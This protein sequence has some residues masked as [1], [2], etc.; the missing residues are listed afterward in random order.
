M[1]A[2]VALFAS[3][4]G[5]SLSL[6]AWGSDLA[7]DAK[8]F[9]A[10]E[11]VSDPDL[12]PDGS[13][14]I[15]ITPGP[16]RK[17]VAVVGNL[18]TGQFQ[19]MVSA[20]GQPES[21][22]WC[23][24]A[25]STRSVCRFGGFVPW[26][27]TVGNGEPVYFSRLV[28]LD[29]DGTHAKLLGQ[30]ETAH[31][32]WIRQTDGQIIDWLDSSGQV[33]VN[34]LYM[35]ESDTVGKLVY[36]KKRGW[37]VDKLDVTSLRSEVVESPRD[38]T[39]YMTDGLGHVRIMVVTDTRN[40]G[41]LTGKL[42]YFYRT[43]SSRDWKPLFEVNDL[44]RPDAQPLAI[45]A[46]NNS[47]YA[48]KKKDGRYALYAIRLDRSLTETLVAENPRVDID[49]VVRFGEAQR[50]I[51]YTYTQ[52]DQKTV[53][54]DPEFN[55]LAASLSKALPNTPLIDFTDSS[56]DGRKLLIFAG[57]DRDPGRYYVFD[58]D[59]KSLTP[60]MIARPEL[61][62]RTLASVKAVTIPASDGAKIPAYLTLPPGKTEKG[63]PAVVLPHGGPESRDRGG[64]DW[65]A[66]FL[67]ARGYAVL[68]P[69]FRGSAGFGDAWLNENGFKNWRTSIGDID[70]SAKWLVSQGIA[71]PNKIAILGWSY[72]GYAALQTAATDPTMY[73]AVIAIAPVTDLSLLKTQ[74]QNYTNYD[75]VVNEIGNG[76]HVMQG[77]PVNN[78]SS[79]MAPVLLVHGTTDAN[80]FYSQS[81][82]ME[83]ALK[84]AGK[85][86]ELLT[87]KD[88]D[89][90][91]D[92]S[93]SRTQ[94]LVRIGELLDRTIGH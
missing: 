65:L 31:D 2:S 34:R 14:V 70:V 93:D 91:L 16:G 38:A 35:P 94:M 33:L 29:T 61:E 88:L 89:H 11:A 86:S 4:V 47:L 87:F 28:A 42:R 43:E 39:S 56:R 50:V 58:R 26:Q 18:E 21:L 46:S 66:Q 78:A 20:D 57:S 72:G 30:P 3:A 67:A 55:A 75:L 32:E 54:F 62:G 81:Q 76:P 73:K 84:S 80:V 90:Q 40:S 7:T 27:G 22:S 64:F 69:E 13:S 15:Y 17:S 92:D 74:A 23:H 10:R 63:L 1:K 24:F 25:S 45:D 48:L 53:Y 59:K 51:G 77:S 41:S 83:S 71:D 6:P 49:D 68:Q 19:T 82:K 9:A 85:Q 5:L 8:A 36:N 37:G 12:S 52:E 44:A 60:A 79:I